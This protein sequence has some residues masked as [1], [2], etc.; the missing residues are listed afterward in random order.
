M[1]KIYKKVKSKY[2]NYGL[3]NLIILILKYPYKRLRW[4]LALNDNTIEIFNT[5]HDNRLWSSPESIS[6]KG[7]EKNYT[8]NLR[9]WLIENIPKYGIR[10]VVDAPCGDFNWMR[11]VLSDVSVNYIGLDIVEELIK[12]NKMKYSSSNIIFKKSNIIDEA[13]PDCDLLIV[14]D[15]LFH[16]SY[17]D[18]NQFLKNIKK[19]NYKYLLTTSHIV[20]SDFKNFD[21]KT[22][23]FRKIDLFKSPF[24]FSKD[25]VLECINDFPKGHRVEKSLSLIQKEFVPTNISISQLSN[26]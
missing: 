11:Y 26:D 1:K 22:G 18:I 3:I 21:I 23:D 16:F 24:N 7:S 4:I 6:G 25:S 20:S 14:R 19:T 12:I 15:C 2:K 9:I 17:A 13:I 8:Q 10:N 5:I